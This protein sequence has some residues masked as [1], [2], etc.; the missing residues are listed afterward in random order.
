MSE[1]GTARMHATEPWARIRSQPCS[2]EEAL[3]IAGSHGVQIPAYIRFDVCEEFVP[4]G[5]HASYLMLGLMEGQTAIQWTDCLNAD[6][7]VPVHLRPSVLESDEAIMAVFAH[8]V[9]EITALRA[10]FEANNGVLLAGE[11]YRLISPEIPR[12][13]HSE[14]VDMADSLVLQMRSQ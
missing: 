3:A 8:E 4:L 10:Q 13:L 9:H 7:Q 5:A 6:G 14:A 12:N 1:G 2:I 11:I